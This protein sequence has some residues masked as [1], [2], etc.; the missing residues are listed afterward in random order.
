[1]KKSGRPSRQ[2]SRPSNG[3]RGTLPTAGSLH[4]IDTLHVRGHSKAN[5]PFLTPG[6]IGR[7]RP[8]LYLCTFMYSGE[9]TQQAL[10]PSEEPEEPGRLASGEGPAAPPR[11]PPPS[12]P[13]HATEHTRRQWDPGGNRVQVSPGRAAVCDGCECARACARAVG[14]P[15]H[16]AVPGAC[17]AHKDGSF[18]I[19]AGNDPLEA[20][21]KSWEK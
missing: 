9:Y 8:G 4:K 15:P 13:A 3:D 20:E 6:E 14:A 2:G 16:T 7:P 10:R 19:T 21:I 5:Y 18:A 1:M 12:T 11:R 17:S